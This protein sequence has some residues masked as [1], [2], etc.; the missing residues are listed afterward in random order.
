MT[1]APLKL[2]LPIERSPKSAPADIETLAPAVIVATAVLTTDIPTGVC[3]I[4]ETTFVEVIAPAVTVVVCDPAA[5]VV[6]TFEVV[7]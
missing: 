4:V 2:A 1:E 7:R 5:I 6:K 3:A